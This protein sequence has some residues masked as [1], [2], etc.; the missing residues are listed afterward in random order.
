MVAAMDLV[1]AAFNSNGYADGRDRGFG[2]RGP[3]SRGRECDS[4][5]R[6]DGCC[7]RDNN[8][9]HGLVVVPTPITK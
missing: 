9:D 7:G 8:R 3:D 2:G 6:D 4:C 1:A 5:V